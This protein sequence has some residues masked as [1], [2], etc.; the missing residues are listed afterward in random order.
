MNFSTLNHKSNAAYSNNYHSSHI[1][2][3]KSFTSDIH[4]L[5]ED[6]V[7]RCIKATKVV[8]ELTVLASELKS[9][10]ALFYISWC[11]W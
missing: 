1:K 11:P 3:C 8:A 6:L 5:Y 4:K 7:L 9:I 2:F 10:K